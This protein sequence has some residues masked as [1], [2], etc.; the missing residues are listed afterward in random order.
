M[1]NDEYYKTLQEELNKKRLSVFGP[2][3]KYDNASKMLISMI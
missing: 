3:A 2:D 1:S